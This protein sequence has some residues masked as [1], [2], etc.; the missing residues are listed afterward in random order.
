MKICI[1]F[2]EHPEH[3][4]QNIIWREKCPEDGLSCKV[5]YSPTELQGLQ[6]QATVI[7]SVILLQS[8][9]ETQKIKY[10]GNE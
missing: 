10:R 5:W 6:F 1:C 2:C 3:K 8:K 7:L 9:W 4:S